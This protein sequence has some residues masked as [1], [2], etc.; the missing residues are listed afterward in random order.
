[1]KFTLSFR[2]VSSLLVFSILS[3]PLA[4]IGYAQSLNFNK[5]TRAPVREYISKCNTFL[6]PADSGA[7]N[8]K[9]DDGMGTII[10]ASLDP[11]VVEASLRQ[12]IAENAPGY[13]RNAQLSLTGVGMKNADEK[14]TAFEA[15]L[16]RNG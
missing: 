3:A 1:M 14:R 8:N 16:T 15:M 12:A 11:S 10:A 5:E 2:V 6:T 4:N 9:V 13:F 7:N